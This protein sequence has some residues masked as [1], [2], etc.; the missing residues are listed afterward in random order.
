MRE[1]DIVV[2]PTSTKNKLLK[3]YSISNNLVK[4]KFMSKKEY[5]SNY[6]F[7]YDYKTIYYL[8]NKYKYNLDVVKVYLN[9]LYSIDINKEYKPNKINLLKQI[10]KEL[11][12]NN[13]LYINNNFKEFI[14]NK[15]IKVLNYY[16]LEKFEEEL[17][18]QKIELSN[19]YKELNV[20]EFNTLEE[21]VNYVCIK[22][23]ELLNQG[24]NIN[25]IKLTGI[26]D[27]YLY[28]I[29]RLFDYYKIPIN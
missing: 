9:N 27:D 12:D 15:N 16:E 11:L 23:I 5:I 10:K 20:Y 4:T 18:N 17:F 25:K 21:E 6:Y 2:C 24:I 19:N 3:E 29:K 26:N 28:T 13:L 8:M 22:I 1:L 14:S 7:S